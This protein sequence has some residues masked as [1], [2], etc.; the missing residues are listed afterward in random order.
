MA[1][2]TERMIGAAKLD[3]ATYEEVENDPTAMG[4]AMTVVVLAA[5]SA[6]IG[7]IRYAGMTGLVSGTLGAL[8]G[9]F[10]WAGVVFLVGTKLLPEPQTKADFGEL[11]RTIGFSASP[12]VLSIMGVIPIFGGLVRILLMFWQ[13]AA[14]VVAVRAALD[15][16]TTGKAVVVCL[17]GWLAY[18]VVGFFLVSLVGIG[19]AMMS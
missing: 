9:W 11:L 10:L 5:V 19:S 7:T 2:L 13:L 15:Y 6:G 4:Q 16:Q 1:S 3:A 14:M 8:V 18:V 17:I 12:G